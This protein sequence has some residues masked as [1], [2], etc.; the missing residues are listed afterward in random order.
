MSELRELYVDCRV[1]HVDLLDSMSTLQAVVKLNNRAGNE[2]FAESMKSLGSGALSVA[3]WAGGHTLDLLDK[4]IKTAGAQLTKTFDSNKSL[5][6]KIP[7]AMKD[8]ENHAFTFS[9]PLVGA[10]TST[11]QWSDFGSDLDELIKTLE[12]FQK[13]AHDVKDHLS[14]ELVV[15]RKLKSVKTTNDV[16]NVVREFEG[17]HYPEYKLPHKNGEWMVSE[18]L[19]GGRVIKC[20]FKDND[21][22]YSMS[23][24]KPAGESHTLEASKSDLQSVLAKVAKLNDLHLQVKGS[25]A[26]YLDFVK[27]WSSVVEEASKGLSET[28]NV[29]SQIISEAESILKGNA[30]ALAFYSGFTPRVVSYVD[31]YIQD[32]LGVLSKVI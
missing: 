25:Y 18:V 3:K 8:D 1:H 15:A 32:V 6:G 13:H 26:D 27:S 29:G 24:D 23:G 14:R 5:I 17:L 22:V 19:P 7:N 30:H 21:V 4:G 31:K 9:G 28:T 10:L 20:K 16:M 2:D 11:G 12:G